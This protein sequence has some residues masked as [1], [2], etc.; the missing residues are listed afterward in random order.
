[1]NSSIFIASGTIS[2][3]MK[4]PNRFIICCL[5]TMATIA[6]L[7]VTSCVKSAVFVLCSSFAPSFFDEEILKKK[8][9]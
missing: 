7:A 5:F 3:F 9:L 6:T 4:I 1:M 8:G 2:M